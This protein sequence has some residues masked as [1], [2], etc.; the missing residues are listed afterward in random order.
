MSSIQNE[1]TKKLTT[2]RELINN[3]NF[4]KAENI[5][6]E[7]IQKAPNDFE[8]NLN[9]GTIYAKQMKFKDAVYFLEVAAKQNLN[10]SVIYNNLGLIYSH[11]GQ[12]DKALEVLNKV[13]S[14]NSATTITYSHLGIAYTNLSRIFEAK[15][16][17]KKSLDL[18]PKNILS[19]YNY[20]SLFKRLGDF[21]NS[22]K[23]LLNAILVS[24]KYFPSYNN[25]ME[26]YD[27]SNQ[28]QKFKNLLE[29]AKKIFKSNIS[30]D[31]F[32]AKYLFK[33]K[34][35]KKVIQ[36]LEKIKFEGKEKYKEHNRTEV[37]A[38]SFDHLS[39]FKFAFKYFEETNK[40][41][42]DLNK[43]SVD[44][45]KYISAIDQRYQFF[46]SQ[47]NIIWNEKKYNRNEQEPVFLIG[48]PRSGTTLL[49]TI[50]R[51][52]PLIDVLEE[53]PIVDRFTDKLHEKINFDF[54]KLENKD[55]DKEMED[56]YIKERKKYISKKICKVIIDKMPLNTVYVAE[57]LRFF[58]NSKFI[59]AIRHPADC[60]L[61]CFMQNFK[62]NNAMSNFL[63][64][65]DAA[66]LYDKVMNLWTL[67]NEKLNIN[68]HMIRYE[69]VVLNFEE[70]IK[71]ILHF[72]DLN[73][74]NEVTEFYKTA[75]NRGILN[76]PS[77]N[78]VSQPLY[79]KSIGRWKNY[80]D[81]FKDINPILDKWIQKFG[82]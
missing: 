8:A 40:I 5:Y 27:K 13:I 64:L 48:F 79:S 58:P 21:K 59:F 77:Y 12:N 38:K 25:L 7:I 42:Y 23:Y 28:N 3:N 71:K 36:I 57:I 76:T 11:L 75:K 16:S 52:H 53:K 69:D 46:K 10:V 63:N 47:K 50:L 29:D 49:D 19:L 1:I 81:E 61:S 74:S 51:S 82:Y 43:N 6:K 45:N 31:L 66:I 4:L 39:K 20:G 33:L 17:Y 68:S 73:W 15:Q 9:L 41:N 30:L 65:S 37:L 80:Q 78:Q 34:E 24:P 55:L 70:Q 56:F 54:Y 2:A 60:V 72:L 22:E 44:K 18:D 35:Y 67:Y 32:E 62:L 14:L 26:L